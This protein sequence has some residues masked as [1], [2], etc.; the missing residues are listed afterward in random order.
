METTVLPGPRTHKNPRPFPIHVPPYL[1]SDF[2]GA[3][4]LVGG[5][6]VLIRRQELSLG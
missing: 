5:G 1:W 6:G 3:R 4:C 2:G